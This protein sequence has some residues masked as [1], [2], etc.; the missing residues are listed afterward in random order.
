MHDGV[1][2]ELVSH[3]SIIFQNSHIT[4]RRLETHITIVAVVWI[5]LLQSRV[6]SLL[7]CLERI[8]G[9]AEQTKGLIASFDAN[10][11]VVVRGRCARQGTSTCVKSE[12]EAKKEGVREPLANMKSALQVLR[13]TN[14]VQRQISPPFSYESID[15]DLQVLV[16]HDYGSRER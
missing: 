13:S 2:F 1:I 9:R 7:D 8:V 5:V 10:I 15:F 12:E 3:D 11:S 14:R 6:E 16:R 4:A